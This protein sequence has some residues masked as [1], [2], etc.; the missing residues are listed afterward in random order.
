MLALRRFKTSCYIHDKHL[1]VCTDTLATVGV[2]HQG[3]VYAL[4]R[5][6]QL[7]RHLLLLWSQKHLEC[8]APYHVPGELNRAADKLSRQPA[9]PGEWR[10]HPEVVQLIWRRFGDAQVDLFA[11][12]DTSIATLFYSLSEGDPR[13][14]RAA[15][16]WPRGLRKYAFPPVSLL[17]QHPVQGQGGRGAGPLGGAVLAQSDWFPEPVLLATAPPWQFPLKR[18]LLS[19]RGAPSGTRF[20]TCGISTYGPWTGRGGSR[21][22]ISIGSKHHHFS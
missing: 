3:A 22:A 13:H 12:P 16:S 20:Q 15:H 14:G 18:D 11:S 4:R 19:Q 9:L 8:F 5:M 21:W 7:A 2:H 6:S 10:L 1:L 17:A